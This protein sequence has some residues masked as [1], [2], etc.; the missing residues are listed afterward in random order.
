MSPHERD[1]DVRA[2]LDDHDRRTERIRIAMGGTEKVARV[3]ARGANTI[4][5]RIAALVDP[6]SFEEVGTFAFSKRIDDREETPGDGKV[7]GF[8]TVDGRPVVLYGDDVT[9]RQGSSAVVG[10]RKTRRLDTLAHRAGCPVI[11]IGETGGGRIPDILGAA[12]I[13]GV[14]TSPDK[15]TRARDVP[16]VAV[17]VGRSFGGSSVQS[18]RSDFTVQV[19]GS[20]LAITSPRVFEVA[21]GE[22]ISFEELGGVD[23]HAEVTGQIDLAVDTEQE[24]W[25]AVRQWL[26]YLPSNA[27]EPAPVAAAA[28]PSAPLDRAGASAWIASADRSIRRVLEGVVDAGSAFELRP[29]IG[30]GTVTALARIGGRPV[31]VLATDPAVGDGAIDAD[32]CEKAVRLLT[33]C[34]A[35][36]LPVV[37]LVDSAGFAPDDTGRNERILP[38]AVRLRQALALATCPRVLVVVGRAAGLAFASAHRAGWG[39]HGTFAWPTATLGSGPGRDPL[40]VGSADAAQAAGVLGVD[41]LITPEDTRA[42][43]VQHLAR[44]DH[45][46]VPEPDART[47]RTWSTC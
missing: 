47:L 44:L 7:G 40:G 41:E 35:F 30:R 2:A 22:R 34:D 25:S 29:R 46:Q 21:I 26:S 15:A 38:R 10:M 6:G 16:T 28:E 45:R 4:R 8:A 9:V 1:A 17:I 42:V 3:H 36:D 14:G 31:G 43:L 12:G 32:G 27:W 19:R 33:L 37:S 18:A 20:C 39:H 5:D 23:V 11:D 13:T 24:A